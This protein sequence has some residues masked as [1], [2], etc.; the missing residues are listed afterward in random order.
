MF[1]PVAEKFTVPPAQIPAPWSE[2]MEAVG[3]F[4]PFTVMLMLLLEA[5][6]G[7]AHAKLLVIWQVR[8]SPFVKDALVY[9]G[10]FVP[11]L[12]PFSFH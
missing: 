7:E 8:T 1:V 10:L 5:G 11:T 9:T 4:V 6:T 12:F 2:V 3:A